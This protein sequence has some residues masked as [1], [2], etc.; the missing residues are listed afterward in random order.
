MPNPADRFN[1]SHPGM[2]DPLFEEEVRQEAYQL[3]ERAGR[4][5]GRDLEFWYLA[6]RARIEIEHFKEMPGIEAA[7]RPNN[8]NGHGAT[9]RRRRLSR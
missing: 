7:G 9:A 4:P 5:G 6:V 2:N 1:P 8:T 3:W